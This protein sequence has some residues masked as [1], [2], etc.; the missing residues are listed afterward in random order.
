MIKVTLGKCW[1]YSY[2][3]SCFTVTIEKSLLLQNNSGTK[4]VTEMTYVF[5]IAEMKE[6]YCS[7]FATQKHAVSEQNI[8]DDIF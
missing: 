6:N 2:T 1:L 7:T 8:D 5:V 3:N 4:L